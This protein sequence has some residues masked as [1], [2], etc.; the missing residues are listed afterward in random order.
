[1]PDAPSAANIGARIRE[2]RQRRA[3][4]VTELARRVNVTIA[5]VSQWEHGKRP[6][7]Q[8][9]VTR[10]AEALHT[11]VAYLLTGEGDPEI[12]PEP[13]Q[14]TIP[15][16]AI[17]VIAHARKMIANE[18]GVPLGAV[19]VQISIPPTPLIGSTLEIAE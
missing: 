19:R 12:I 1:M 17:D 9:L 15:A 16:A 11:H 10:L 2:L 14:F 4:T 13:G 8:K 6:P 7:A 3:L 18:L 5:C